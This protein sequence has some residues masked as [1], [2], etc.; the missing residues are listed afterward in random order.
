MGRPRKNPIEG[1]AGESAVATLPAEPQDEKPVEKKAK[2]AAMFYWTGALPKAGM[3]KYKRP[4][5]DQSSI[6]NT[7]EEFCTYEDATA[8]RLW[9][10]WGMWSGKCKYAQNITVH[11]HEFQGTTSRP[12]MQKDENT[13]TATL[14]FDPLPGAVVKWTKEQL[15]AIIKN[16]CNTYQREQNGKD[17]ENNNPLTVRFL[18]FHLAHAADSKIDPTGRD[19][20]RSDCRN[21]TYEHDPE[22]DTCVSEFVYI[23]PLPEADPKTKPED[24]WTLTRT[25][26]DQFF[27]NPP[28]S[29]A[30]ALEAGELP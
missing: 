30:E 13:G 23:V 24:Y 20:K 29:L 11:G 25:T 28:K 21:E 22:R 10:K 4:S 16:T 12:I 15:K 7:S 2:Q 3:F 6:M 19:P 9:N 14:M 26:L 17:A 27:A 18:D 1:E 8:S 5:L